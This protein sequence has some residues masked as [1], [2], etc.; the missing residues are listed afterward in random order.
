MQDESDEHDQVVVLVADLVA[1]RTQ[2]VARRLVELLVHHANH[3]PQARLH[4]EAQLP[5]RLV[6]LNGLLAPA[7]PEDHVHDAL[8][9]LR[10]DERGCRAVGRLKRQLPQVQDVHRTLPLVAITSVGNG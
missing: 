2:R 9:E 5:A 8:N 6:D 3:D 1:Q 7:S 4:S 10:R